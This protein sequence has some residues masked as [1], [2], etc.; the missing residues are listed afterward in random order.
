MYVS[1]IMYG[2]SLSVSVENLAR[3]LEVQEFGVRGLYT[4]CSGIP[5]WAVSVFC[6]MPKPGYG[7]SRYGNA[8]TWK[9]VGISDS[10]SWNL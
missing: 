7:N 9:G 2:R 6:S 1:L 10:P 5:V 3:S 8:I 4:S